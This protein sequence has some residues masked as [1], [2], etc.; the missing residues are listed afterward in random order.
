MSAFIAVMKRD[1]AEA[2]SY[3]NDDLLFLELFETYRSAEEYIS[4]LTQVLVVTLCTT[5]LSE[6]P[7]HS[8]PAQRVGR[9]SFPISCAAA[10]TEDSTC[11]MAYWAKAVGLYRPLAYA[12]TDADTKQGWELIQKAKILNRRRSE[13]ETM[14]RPR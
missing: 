3:P 13:K 5:Q 1:I 9:V 4:A 8:E 10:A 14:W 7:P 6:R 12:P 2:R 11:A